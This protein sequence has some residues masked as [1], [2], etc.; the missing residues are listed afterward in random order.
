[1]DSYT[2][3]DINVVYYDGKLLPILI[4]SKKESN[5]NCCVYYAKFINNGVR[6]K[7]SDIDY[8]F[9]HN[10]GANAKVFLSIPNGEVRRVEL[11][12]LWGAIEAYG[13]KIYMTF[14]ELSKIR[15]IKRAPLTNDSE[16]IKEFFNTKLNNK[17]IVILFSELQKEYKN[18]FS[19]QK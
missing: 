1:M 2:I 10:T 7:I 17:Q 19:L 3:K 6:I 14:P 13:A 9:V 11:G 4:E 5:T 16:I 15:S 8:G 18:I 12:N